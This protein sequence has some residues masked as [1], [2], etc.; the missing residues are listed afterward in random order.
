MREVLKNPTCVKSLVSTDE[1]AG[2]RLLH[3]RQQA[4]TLT[5][6]RLPH[7]R[8][9]TANYQERL[10]MTIHVES[11]GS[12]LGL[13]SN[14]GPKPRPLHIPLQTITPAARDEKKE[15]KEMLRATGTGTSEKKERSNKT[16]QIVGK[17]SPSTVRTLWNA[18]QSCSSNPWSPQMSTV[19]VRLQPS[20][21]V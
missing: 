19:V 10:T 1:W 9:T 7:S 2:A 16:K 14:P 6:T 5:G 13:A 4:Q 17:N 20:N 15:G 11:H 3:S 18:P 21:K 12:R 8:P